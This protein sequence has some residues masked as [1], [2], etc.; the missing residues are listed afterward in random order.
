MSVFFLHTM[1]LHI[2]SSTYTTPLQINIHHKTTNKKN[3]T[4]QTKKQQQRNQFLAAIFIFLKTVSI[5]QV[6]QSFG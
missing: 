2:K 6:V 4:C 3:T 5:L 1:Y